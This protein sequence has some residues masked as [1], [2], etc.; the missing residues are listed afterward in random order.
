MIA[1]ILLAAALAAEPQAAAAGPRL[2]A[3]ALVAGQ[4]PD[5]AGKIILQ[6]KCAICHGTDYVVQQRLKPAQWEA[7]VA[8]MR[9]F[10]A[11]LSDDE[12]KT[13]SEYLGATWTI[14]LPAR[15]PPRP[16]RAP[17]GA[18]PGK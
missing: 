17:R 15:T 8:K 10:G 7:E 6:S 13:L 3:A 9:K 5:G 11:P 16:V 1:G 12:A 18:V 2:E 4:L 14:D